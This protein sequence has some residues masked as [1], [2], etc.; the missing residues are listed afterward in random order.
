MPIGTKVL[1]KNEGIRKKTD[2]LYSNKCTVVDTDKNGNYILRNTLG[3]LLDYPIPLHQLKIIQEPEGDNENPNNIMEVQKILMHRKIN[4]LDEYL[5]KWKNLP[6]SHN[7]WVK[8]KDFE[9]KEIIS[10]FLR[11]IHKPAGSKLGQKSI[12]KFIET[13]KVWR[14]EC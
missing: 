6:S 4:G 13:I 12:K 11:Q 5:V 1:I 10:K 9:T 3:E 14:P 8:E 2:P 7:E